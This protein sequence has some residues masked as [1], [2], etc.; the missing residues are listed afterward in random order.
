MPKKFWPCI[1]GAII[2]VVVL[3]LAID[4]LIIGNN[5]PSNIS[6][7]DWV[8]FLG[9]YLGSIL[10]CAISL[11]GL[12]FT[13]K[14]TKQQLQMSQRQFEEQK[15]MNYIPILDCKFIGIL[16][17]KVTDSISLD[18]DYTLVNK[19]ELF[20]C[21]LEFDVSNIGPGAC[22]G[23][24]YGLELDNQIREG[25]FWFEKDRIIRSQEKLIQRCTIYVPKDK[26]FDPTLLI[27][28]EDVLGNQY[29]KRIALHLFYAE[30]SKELDFAVLKQDN[31][32]LLPKLQEKLYYVTALNKINL[33]AD[34]SNTD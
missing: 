14:F 19:Q 6:N 5:F 10:G 21:T 34:E 12:Y 8:D 16:V 23:I 20:P 24:K 30:Q 17:G 15:R 4:W 29:V 27:Y 31:G 11:I 2:A 3:P 32:S 33:R 18:V 13:I 26:Q 1:I 22:I 25:T 7:S 9:G 28:Y